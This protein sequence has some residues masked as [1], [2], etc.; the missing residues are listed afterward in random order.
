MLI[1][2]PTAGEKII[3]I[4][5]RSNSVSGVISLLIRRDGDGTEESRPPLNVVNLGNYINVTFSSSILSEDA[6]YYFEITKDEKL[7]YRDK[8]YVTSQTNND[9]SLNSHKIGN[10]SL[11][12]Q[13]NELDDNTYIIGETSVS[14]NNGSGDGGDDGTVISGDA[15]FILFNTSSEHFIQLDFPYFEQ[16]NATNNPTSYSV[17]NLIDGLSLD[18]A[19]GV[20]TGIPTG[21][22]GAVSMTLKAT[23]EFGE[24]V[25]SIS[26]NLTNESADD[27]LAPYNLYATNATTDGFRL[28]YSLR[29]YNRTISQVEIFRNN[30]LFKTV[31]VEPYVPYTYA[32]L[33]GINGTFDYKVRLKNSLGEYSPFSDI[34]THS[35][36]QFGIMTPNE[37]NTQVSPTLNDSIAYYKFEETN[38]TTL[39]DEL[40]NN[41]GTYQGS[42]D[43]NNNYSG[44][45]GRAGT[46]DERVL[47]SAKVPNDDSFYLGE[48][49]GDEK[50]FSVSIWFK[51]DDTSPKGTRSLISKSLAGVFEWKLSYTDNS[52]STN[53][54]TPYFEMSF[55]DSA[56][57]SIMAHF[58]GRGY[59]FSQFEINSGEWNHFVYSYNGKGADEYNTFVWYLNNSYMTANNRPPSVDSNNSYQRMLDG[60][61]DFI[62]GGERLSSPLQS[63]TSIDELSMF[64]RELTKEEVNFLYN[65][66][67]A[68]S[69]S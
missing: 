57:S 32:V 9:I 59:S 49:E 43:S 54:Q 25:R 12:K 26:Y 17:D 19:T 36:Y 69:L 67:L 33:T 68:N 30:V 65:N 64:N 62:I 21:S 29:E 10:G 23:N 35:V 27:F 14:N 8:I 63:K 31:V 18:S 24:G 6:T 45:L 50:P 58:M 40:G 60:G 56:R 39:V 37:A 2:E 34:F 28:V 44:I 55:R 38:L 20:I 1:L 42:Y 66:G 48:I 7:W 4:M 22:V 41:N 11:Y 61:G 15:P 13:Y 52:T 53:G 16:I 5:P 47:A 46:F 51:I 3:S